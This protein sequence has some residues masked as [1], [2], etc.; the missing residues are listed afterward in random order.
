VT[1]WLRFEK[2]RRVELC[3]VGDVSRCVGLGL[4]ARV[5]GFLVVVLAGA[6]GIRVI[7]DARFAGFLDWRVLREVWMV[8][9]VVG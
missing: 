3:G 6:F 8:E 4:G 2:A 9:E 1:P 7:G 5:V